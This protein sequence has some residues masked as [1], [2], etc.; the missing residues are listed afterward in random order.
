MLQGES[1]NPSHATVLGK[2]TFSGLEYVS[3]GVSV[4]DICYAYDK[5]GLVTVTASQRENN[6]QLGLTVEPVPKDMS[7]LSRA[8]VEERE[9][10]LHIQVLIA[11]DLS[12]S[13]SG[14]PLRE[15]RKAA[16][17]FME[18]LDLGCTSVGLIGFA[19]Q[20]KIASE[21]SQD[22]R[23]LLKGVNSWTSWMSTGDLGWG[24]EA[25]PFSQAMSLLDHYDGPRFLIVLTDGVWCYQKEAVKQAEVLRGMGVE[26]IALGFGSADKLFLKAIATCDENALFAD[27]K[28]LTSSFSKI[29]QVLTESAAAGRG[30]KASMVFLGMGE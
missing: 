4:L 25:E 5:N 29:A 16:R 28:Q 18:Q 21:F 9:T 6:N 14:E 30:G 2:Y 17:N 23:R 7:W 20:V 10:S 22:T 1:E 27:L 15:A 26:I 24:N 12:G 19:D 8:P 11:V 3:G 13:M